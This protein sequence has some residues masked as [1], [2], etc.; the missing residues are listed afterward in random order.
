[1]KS[2]LNLREKEALDIFLEKIRAALGKNLLE[3]RLFGSKAR[4]GFGLESDIDVLLVLKKSN[5]AIIDDIAVIL[6]D[7]QLKYDANISPVIYTEY[8]IETNKN[9]SSPFISTLER[10]SISV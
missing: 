6:V 4:G 10:E 7:I 8:E 3:A 9:L 5:L 1:M 2:Y